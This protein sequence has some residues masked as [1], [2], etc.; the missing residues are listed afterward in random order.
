LFRNRRNNG[1]CD[2]TVA[3]GSET[4][5]GGGRCSGG[6]A[7]QLRTRAFWPPGVAVATPR[8]CE[9]FSDRPT[10]PHPS[11][12][13]SQMQTSHPRRT[14]DYRIQEAIC[15]SG[16]RDLFPELE[17][18]RSTVR[19]WIHRGLPDVVTNDLVAHDRAY[20]VAEIHQLHH[21]S[22]LLGA[23]VGLLIAML[24][25][26]KVQLDHERLPDGDAKKI[27]L[28]AIAATQ[29]Q[30]LSQLRWPASAQ[31]RSCRSARRSELH[32]RRPPDITVGVRWKRDA[33]STIS[34]AVRESFPRA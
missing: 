13:E 19:S 8:K 23:V 16:D 24:R 28:R 34:P 12:D 9:T 29:S 21:R 15:E 32:D 30:A 10:L 3:R 6:L 20:L 7:A 27:L 31:G 2:P 4:G 33:N 11:A 26:S 1:R 22:A 14:Y 25:I 18:S 5:P 17:I